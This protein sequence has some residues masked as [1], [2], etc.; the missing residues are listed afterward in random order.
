MIIINF[1][2]EIFKRSNS[3]QITWSYLLSKIDEE[4]EV[5]IS[6]F[7]LVSKTKLNKK[8]I[9]P[10]L[11]Y[12]FNWF[13]NS[14]F[15]FLFY[16]D[17]NEIIISKRDKVNV[18]DLSS[19]KPKKTASPTKKKRVVKKATQQ[20]LIGNSTNKYSKEIEEIVEYLNF[21]ARANFNPENKGIVSII[22]NRLKEGFEISQFKYIIDIKTHQWLNTRNQNYLRPST[23]FSENNMENY[24]NEKYLIQKEQSLTLQ[25]HESA[26]SAKSILA[27]RHNQKQ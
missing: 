21:K 20:I 10:I 9:Y 13:L 25:T 19:F 12:G 22:A 27:D 4:K 8:T 11:K 17:H 5:R 18:K 3:Y 24:V 16:L 2:K 26:E 15:E 1:L 6:I 7:E 14:N 23:L